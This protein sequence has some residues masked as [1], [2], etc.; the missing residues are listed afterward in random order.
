VATVL[1]IFLRIS[2]P[3]LVHLSAEPLKSRS[4]RPWPRSCMR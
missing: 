3:H 4:P 1:I 2:R